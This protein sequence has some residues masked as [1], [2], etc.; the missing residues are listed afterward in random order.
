MA[1]AADYDTPP[2]LDGV[3]LAGRHCGLARLPAGY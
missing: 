2:P 3:P 1:E